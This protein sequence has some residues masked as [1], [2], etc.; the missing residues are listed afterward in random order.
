MVFML[1]INLITNVIDEENI[2]VTYSNSAKGLKKNKSKTK[3][4]T[5][6]KLISKRSRTSRI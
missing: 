6:K 3:S 1:A 2:T 5:G 4:I